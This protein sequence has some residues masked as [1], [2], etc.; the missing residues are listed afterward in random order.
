MTLKSPL[1][2]AAYKDIPTTYLLSRN[3]QGLPYE[4]QKELVEGAGVGI[5]TVTCDADHSPF[6]S[7]PKLVEQVIRKA[8]GEHI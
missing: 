3:D 2:Y 4:R 5:T 1:K 6:L 8:A 7:Q